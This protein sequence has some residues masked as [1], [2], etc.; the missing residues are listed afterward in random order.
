M[1]TKKHENYITRFNPLFSEVIPANVVTNVVT[2][3]LLFY[4]HFSP[5]NHLHKVLN[6]NFVL[7][8]NNSC[9]I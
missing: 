1:K 6:Q 9:F 5:H 2:N 4:K 3:V 8:C 7:L